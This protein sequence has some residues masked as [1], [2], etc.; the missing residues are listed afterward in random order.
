M[1]VNEIVRKYPSVKVSTLFKAP[2]RGIQR[3][4]VRQFI[5][6]SKD[7]TTYVVKGVSDFADRIYKEF[8]NAKIFLSISTDRTYWVD[9]TEHWYL[10]TDVSQSCALALIRYYKNAVDNTFRTLY[11]PKAGTERYSVARGDKVY[12]DV[13]SLSKRDGDT[14]YFKFILYEYNR[15]DEATA[16]E[17]RSWLYRNKMVGLRYRFDE[18]GDLVSYS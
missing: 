17:T 8:P 6:V 12:Y 3:E 10:V 14:S 16:N 5:A 4:W 9:L 13:M 7:S 1:K 18:N 2:L 15:E 11:V